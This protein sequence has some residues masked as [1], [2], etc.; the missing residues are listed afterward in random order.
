MSPPLHFPTTALVKAILSFIIATI[1]FL[2]SS[3]RFSPLIH[4]HHLRLACQVQE[5]QNEQ[6]ML[7]LSSQGRL[8][9]HCDTGLHADTDMRRV[10]M[11]T[12]E[13]PQSLTSVETGRRWWKWWLVKVIKGRWSSR[14]GKV[15]NGRG[16]A[17]GSCKSQAGSSN[18]PDQRVWL[19]TSRKD[20]DTTLKDLAFISWRWGGVIKRLSMGERHNLIFILGCKFL[21]YSRTWQNEH[22]IY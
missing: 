14:N 3:P 17:W 21:I 19:G 1:Y 16:H 2:T 4:L 12:H 15:R 22:K 18:I 9:H 10:T 11:D 8:T 5:M 7:L 13:R 20:L 6:E